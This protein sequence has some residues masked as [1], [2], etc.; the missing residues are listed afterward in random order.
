[1]GADQRRG[2]GKAELVQVRPRGMADEDG[3]QDERRQQAGERND[4]PDLRCAER[5]PPA[6]PTTVV[7]ELLRRDGSH[8]NAGRIAANPAAADAEQHAKSEDEQAGDEDG[9]RSI[10]SWWPTGVNRSAQEGDVVDTGPGTASVAGRV[11][12]PE[13]CAAVRAFQRQVSLALGAE[14]GAERKLSSSTAQSGTP[15]GR[16]VAPEGSAIAGGPAALSAIPTWLTRG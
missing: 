11:A 9:D 16:S 2:E 8:P 7:S 3:T 13:G 5:M 6:L 15:R 12:R 10:R 1:M 4:Q 14:A